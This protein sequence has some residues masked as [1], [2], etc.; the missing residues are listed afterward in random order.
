M[1][2]KTND[3]RP[4]RIL[5]LEDSP[6]DAEITQERLITAGFSMHLDWASNEPEFKSFLQRSE[7]DLILADYQ[8]P[9]FD[10]PA[11]LRLA[12]SLSPDVPFICVSGTIGEDKAVELLK[13]GATDY[14]LK[15]QIDKLPLTMQ[16]ALDEINGRKARR[17][18]EEA[19]RESEALFRKLFEDHAAVKLL[20]DPDTGDIIDANEAAA[21]FYGWS[22]EQLRQMKIQ[23]INTLSPEEVKKQMEKV[24]AR[25][26][27]HLEFRHRRADG[28]VRD[29]DVFSSTIEANKRTRIHSIVYDIT[30]RKAAEAALQA[31]SDEV[32]IMTQQLWQAAKLATMGELSASIAHEMNNPLATV[33]LRVESLIAQATGDD[34]RRRE[35]EIIGQEVER[36]GNLVSNLLQFSRRSIQQISTVNVC[37][38][39]EKT[40]ELIQYHFRKHNIA[41]AREFKPEAPLIH[42]DRQQLRQLFLNLFTNAS[43]AMPEGGTLTI[44]VTER[45]EEKQICIEIT[46]TGV[47]I[48]PE[49]LPKVLEPFYTTKTEGKGTG[50]GL[51]IC[52]RIA[53]NHS[54]QL[55]IM[56]DGVP[57]KGSKICVTLSFSIGS[58]SAC[59][60]DE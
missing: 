60:D 52:R 55:E 49:I 21:V 25:Q 11:A 18:A 53:N 8:L 28:S 19:L 56:S 39:I 23:E 20:L 5:Y 59:L 10:A 27:T 30:E 29:V 32:K 22:R 4:L 45:P 38:E 33:G 9:D 31:S 57:G 24:R 1:N 6:R 7:Y 50:L 47:G 41:V 15:G 42:A 2:K 37:D 13:Q 48:P 46:D 54:G 3:E 40:L 51:A 36:M 44:R 34:P 58:N 43:D 35:L 14:V 12:E 17:L 16:R 26:K